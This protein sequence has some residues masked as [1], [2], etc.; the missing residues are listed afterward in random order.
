MNGIPVGY[1]SRSLFGW[2]GDMD[3]RPHLWNALS[4]GIFTIQVVFH[5]PIRADQFSNRKKLREMSLRMAL[6]IG[7]LKKL[8]PA[9][10]KSLASNTCM[11]RV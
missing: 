5:E 9:N 11:K 6:K 10:W 3:L 4:L 8:S 1:S 7:D 2:Y